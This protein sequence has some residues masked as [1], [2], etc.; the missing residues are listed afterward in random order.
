[1][2][3]PSELEILLSYF[4]QFGGA[5]L[6][7]SRILYHDAAGRQVAAARSIRTFY[8]KPLTVNSMYVYIP[9]IFLL[10]WRQVLDSLR[11]DYSQRMTM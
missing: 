7:K 2:G 10:K 9:L 8:E 11:C 5:S 6:H 3:I 4:M 1:M